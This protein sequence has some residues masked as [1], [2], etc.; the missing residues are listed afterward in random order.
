[1]LLQQHSVI[2]DQFNLL[3]ISTN[4][5]SACE[6]RKPKVLFISQPQKFLQSLVVYIQISVDHIPNP[7]VA[8]F[9][10]SPFSMK[11]HTMP[12]LY[13]HLI[14]HQRQLSPS[15]YNL[16]LQLRGK[17]ASRLRVCKAMEAVNIKAISHLSFRPLES[18]TR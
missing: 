10:I 18:S 16:L 13:K 2:S 9:T 17:L 8:R 11:S 14:R 15:F 1:M 4:V 5:S 12:F 6:Q 3:T 7:S